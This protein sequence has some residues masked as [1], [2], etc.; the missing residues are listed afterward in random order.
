MVHIN[1]PLQCS[2]KSFYQF[3]SS[4]ETDHQEKL[5]TIDI[6]GNKNIKAFIQHCTL[7]SKITAKFWYHRRECII[8]TE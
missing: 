2:V 7:G 6:W 8:I 3:Q 1:K 5:V 4:S